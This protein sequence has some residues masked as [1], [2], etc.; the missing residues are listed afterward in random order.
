MANQ[1]TNHPEATGENK[2]GPLAGVRVVDL[3]LLLPGPLCSMYLGDMGAD[4]I[5][6]ENPRMPDL[7]R[8]MGTRLGPD[9]KQNIDAKDPDGGAESESG[10]Y[11]MVNRNKRAITINIK[12]PEGR[13]VLMKL[14]EDADVL[15]EGFRPGTLDAMGIGYEQLKTKFPRLIYC[16]ISGY[17]ASGPYEKLAGHDGNYIGY[18]GLLGITGLADGAPVIPGFQVADIGGGTLAAVGSILAALYSREKTGRGQFLDISMMDGAF[19]FLSLHAGEYVASGQSPE[20]GKMDLSGG[21]P[22]YNVYRCK[23]GRYVILGA[24]EERFFRGF[25]RQVDRE[26]I[27]D[28]VEMTAAGLAAIKPQI[29]EIFLSRDRDDWRELFL[30]PETCLAPVNDIAEAFEDPQLRERGMIQTVQHPRLGEVLQ[31]GSPFRFSDTPCEMRTP[32]PEHGQHTD[33][34]LREAGF[35]D[36]SLAELRKKRAI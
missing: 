27:L 5:K 8:M 3:S 35:D 34:V 1:A 33:E 24:L 22:N 9:G 4:V 14:L 18:S 31:I 6:I 11:L 36:A 2:G 29:E 21:L 23:D 10:L 13:E 17:G 7:T 19:S 12:R 32:P 20:R 28:G 30:N 16:A 25:L 26:D 15:L